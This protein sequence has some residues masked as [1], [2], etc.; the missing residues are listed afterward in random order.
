MGL[1]DF[2]L[3]PI[4]NLLGEVLG[5]LTGAD[6]DGQDQSSGVLVNKQSILTRSLLF[7]AVA[8]LAALGRSYL[9]A[10]ALKTNTCILPWFYQRGRLMLSKKFT[11]TTQSALIANTA[12]W[13]VRRHS[14]ALTIRHIAR[15]WPELI[16]HGEPITAS[17]VLPI[18]QS[19]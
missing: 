2:I 18:L 6:F 19:G 4:Q 15:Y 11:L 9:L 12:A 14:L 1:F 8:R 7:M 3:K 13:L 5:F 16:P 17:E 10:A